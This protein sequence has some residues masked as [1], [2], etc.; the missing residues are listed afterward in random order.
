[1]SL[2][3]FLESFCQLRMI[4]V[5]RLTVHKPKMSTENAA[6]DRKLFVWRFPLTFLRE[7]WW[8][9]TYTHV[10]IRRNLARVGTRRR[11]R[12]RCTCTWRRSWSRC[13][14]ECG[15]WWRSGREG[16]AW[17]CR[18]NSERPKYSRSGRVSEEFATVLEEFE[19]AVSEPAE[20]FWG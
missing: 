9:L 4:A 2:G 17:D 20:L 5:A 6:T 11:W 16:G 15:R 3:T 19:S 12:D 10:R 8:L 18:K 7:I 13:A 1:M 14:S